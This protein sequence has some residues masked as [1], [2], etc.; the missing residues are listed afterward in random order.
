MRDL[1]QVKNIY[2]VFDGL[3]YRDRQAETV[4]KILDA[5][6]KVVALCAPT[7]SGKSLIG[8]VAGEVLRHETDK[9]DKARFAYLVSSKQLQDQIIGD[10][11]EALA[12]KG[13]ANY[14]CGMYEKLRAD[15]CTHTETH[16]C[17]MKYH[18]PYEV[19]KRKVLASPRQILNYHYFLTEA[20]YVGRFSDYPF[21]VS[22]EGDMVEN[23]LSNFVGLSF[24]RRDLN[25]LL[26]SPPEYKTA[27]E[28]R[29]VD[30]WLQWTGRQF[31]PKVSDQIEIV[32]DQLNNEQP[33]S[34]RYLMLNRRLKKLNNLLE[35]ARILKG[36]VDTE[37]ILETMKDGD[38]ALRWTFQPTWLTNKLANTYFWHHG[39]KF[40]LMSATF[41]PV[42]VL[43]KT[44][45]LQPGD[46]TRLEMGSTFP[47]ANR[48]VILNP[49]AN[50]S[51]KTYAEEIDQTLKEIDRLME[52]HKDEKGII[53]TVSY[54]LTDDVMK[55]GNWRL[56]T[57]NTENRQDVLDDFIASKEP[58]VLVSPSFTRGL[59]LPDDLCRFI[60]MPKAPFLS[61]SSKLTSARLWGSGL[62]SLWY[63]SMCAQ[64]IVQASGRG[65]RHDKD[66]ATT[67]LLDR[68]I[69]K[70][71][72]DEQRLFPRYWL[73]AVDV[74]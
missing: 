14:P 22:D 2:R 5:P 37:W 36:N 13:R 17:E 6:G 59:D 16:K 7:G 15:E 8:M 45:G 27:A 30:D 47:T 55:L 53:H 50:L 18:C 10:F 29:G 40:L 38:D 19:Q 69:Y 72:V 48:P 68:Q 41:P 1:E 28:G 70:L 32:E 71:V 11:P 43:A 61:L 64:E 12:M 60:I 4:Q 20:N 39:Q 49:V 52:K 62:G 31:M 51:Y 25:S 34:D 58:L 35:K 63:R 44:L 67:Y 46:I 33:G 54:K 21:I 24:T 74:A 42:Q 3:P 73:D 66:W 57:H 26:I 23:L 65:V 9:H 56:V